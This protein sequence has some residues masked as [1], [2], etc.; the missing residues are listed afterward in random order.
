[1]PSILLFL[2]LPQLLQTSLG[3]TEDADAEDDTGRVTPTSSSSSGRVGGRRKEEK[4]VLSHI[5]VKN[6]WSLLK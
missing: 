6:P 5:S 3:K 1:M 2:V 4:N